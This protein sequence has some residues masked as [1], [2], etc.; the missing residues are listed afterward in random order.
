MRYA[1]PVAIVTTLSLLLTSSGCTDLGLSAPELSMK[2]VQDS[3]TPSFLSDKK[4]S[5]STIEE[6][7]ILDEKP[8]VIKPPMVGDYV[9]FS[10]L[11]LV[12]LE[13]VGLVTG[14]PGTGGDPP[15]S[16]Y[17]TA[18]LEEMRKN[19]VKNPNSILQSPS[20]ALVI[21]RA[22][23]PPL[24]EPGEKFDVEVRIPGGSEVTSL[25]GG[26][27]MPCHL[28]EQAI[29]PG[30]GILEGNVLAKATGPIL[31]S[32][33]EGDASLKAGMLRRGRIVGGATSVKSRDMLIFLRNDF[34]SVRNAKRIAERIGRRFHDYDR[35]GHKV[36][37]AEAKTDQ[38]IIL[39][40][41]PEYK[42]NFPRYIRVIENI[43]FKET[44]VEER[45]RMERLEE[46]LH[47]PHR[48]ENA[49]LQLEAIGKT[50][51]PMLKRCLKADTLESR[52][53][54]A[55]ALAYMRNS[56]GLEVL[57]EAARDEPAFRV[58][59]L[60]AM[61][62]TD[63]V[64]AHLYLEKLMSEPSLET[65]YGAFRAMTV[66]DDRAPFVAG[67]NMNDEFKLHVL[68]TIGDPAIHLTHQ[69][70]AEVVLFGAEQ[71][72]KTPIAIRAGNDILITARG[73]DSTVSV[74][75][76]RLGEPNQREVVSTKLADVIRAVVGMGATYPDVAQMLAQ[77][78]RQENLEGRIGI[79]NL[80]AAGRRYQRPASETGTAAG[81]ATTIGR[82]H[83][84]PNIYFLNS[85]N[86][87]KEALKPT[88]SPTNSI[89]EKRNEE[90]EETKVSVPSGKSNKTTVDSTLRRARTILL[91]SPEPFQYKDGLGDEDE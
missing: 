36:P 88:I 83:L 47:I 18:L 51:I 35:Y 23:L 45:V 6:E 69:Q 62:A 44:D 38:K 37:L 67:E 80:P 9:T 41:Q 76:H 43:S 53:H 11:N 12:L 2:N 78:E 90:Q 48:A 13:G 64:E 84:A 58:F 55:T 28:S 68:Q 26:W 91:G 3:L 77:A 20:T 85:G 22:Y 81:R 89:E 7:F 17:R 10:G 16:T 5:E 40:V 52:F 50:S 79:D 72:L 87:Q 19:N 73:G 75:K 21:V 39:R 4:D 30:K 14:L 29:V 71:E 46:E 60:A 65:R 33:T 24:V 15:A 27:L 57:Y 74:S 63:D 61:A 32:T 34:R 66:L 49:A 1:V 8:N 56:A 70:K 25:N 54:A 82:K 86:E 59:A 42:D 31:V